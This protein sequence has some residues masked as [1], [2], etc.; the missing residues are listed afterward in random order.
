M[1][2]CYIDFAASNVKSVLP[3]LI[4]VFGVSALY[5]VYIFFYVY[6]KVSLSFCAIRACSLCWLTKFTKGGVLPAYTLIS[7]Y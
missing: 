3:P 5:F 6:L 4:P 2:C 1:I 7:V